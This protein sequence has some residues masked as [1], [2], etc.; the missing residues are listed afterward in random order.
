M[1]DAGSDLSADSCIDRAEAI[2]DVVYAT[3]VYGTTKN[4]LYKVLAQNKAV[5]MEELAERARAAGDQAFERTI[6]AETTA[7]IQVGDAIRMTILF[8]QTAAEDFVKRRSKLIEQICTTRRME[9]EGRTMR[10]YDEHTQIKEVTG[11]P[12]NCGLYRALHTVHFP[13]DPKIDD[14]AAG[15][16]TVNQLVQHFE[17]TRSKEHFLER[18]RGLKR[19][20]IDVLAWVRD[21]PCTKDH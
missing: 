10:F 15:F 20:L 17:A 1:P 4:E 7:S 14:P 5:S 16:T 8:L 13:E 9:M 3:Y 19:A 2:P 12:S 18:G 11:S 6:E 21:Q